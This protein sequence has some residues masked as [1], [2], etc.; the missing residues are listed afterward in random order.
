MTKKSTRTFMMCVF[1]VL[2]SM[3]SFL[4]GF[5]VNE[6]IHSK[7]ENKAST[8]VQ[9]RIIPNT[10]DEKTETAPLIHAGVEI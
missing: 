1:L 3:G 4:V 5:S 2:L 7:F 9:F 8:G 10:P 6:V